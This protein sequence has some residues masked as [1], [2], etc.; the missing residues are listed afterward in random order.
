MFHI[1][2][3]GYPQQTF[4]TLTYFSALEQRNIGYEINF[5]YTSKIGDNN[6]YGDQSYKVTGVFTKEEF[7][8]YLVSDDSDFFK[9]KSSNVGTFLASKVPYEAN[10]RGNLKWIFSGL[11]VDD[12]TI[13]IY[14]DSEQGMLDGK[15]TAN[16]TATQSENATKQLQ[17]AF[18]YRVKKDGNTIDSQKT[19]G[20]VVE[21]GDGAPTDNGYRTTLSPVY[22]PY[23]SVYTLT[24]GGDDYVEAEPI[25][26][27]ASDNNV[28]K[29]FK[30]WSVD[31]DPDEGGIS[32]TVARCYNLGFN[33]SMYQNYIVTAVYGNT[34]ST[35][36]HEDSASITWAENGRN[37]WNDKRGTAKSTW[38][39][40]DR[41]FSDFMITFD[42]ADKTLLKTAD[43]KSVTTGMIT[44]RLDTILDANKGT[45]KEGRWEVQTETDYNSLYSSRDSSKAEI[46]DYIQG[47][48]G[49]STTVAYAGMKYDGTK[50]VLADAD[51]YENSFINMSNLD[52]K[53]RIEFTKIVPNISHSDKSDTGRKNYV[54]RAYAYMIDWNLDESGNPESIKS[55]KISDPVYYTIYDIATIANGKCPDTYTVTS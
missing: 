48:E 41:I 51:N 11:N 13:F 34:P 43:K 36:E 49:G 35:R 18:P 30:Y 1:N 10:I 26:Y 14:D 39:Y 17:F 9:F 32:H 31:T 38:T 15:I 22:V 3:K 44:E 53:N 6:Y 4:D 40:G 55:I 42:R 54:Y 8:T 16:M 23:G 33:F 19:S 46:T 29:Y 25:I 7:G 28:A 27:S 21:V 20:K 5:N 37:Q 45:A 47:R 2:N 50:F 24:E 12:S 52:N